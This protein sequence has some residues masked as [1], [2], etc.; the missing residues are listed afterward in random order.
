MRR[1]KSDYCQNGVRV[2]KIN[3][4]KIWENITCVTNEPKC[5]KNKINSLI[6]SNKIIVIDKT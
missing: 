1:V 4:K 2:G 5:H 6:N 3:V